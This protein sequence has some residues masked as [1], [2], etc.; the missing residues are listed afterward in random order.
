[1][2]GSCS[3]TSARR[4]WTGCAP[5][6]ARSSCRPR[7]SSACAVR[8]ATRSRVGR[9][10]RGCSPRSSARTCSSC[11]WTGGGSGIAITACSAS[12]LRRRLSSTSRGARP[13]LHARA[14]AWHLE[15][16][17]VREAVH[18]ALAA[19][20]QTAAR[21]LVATHW[22]R[23]FNRGRL[24]TVRF[25]LDAL[26]AEAVRGDP[27]LCAARAWL[28]LDD[29]RIDE[30]EPWILAAERS[31]AE[32]D[33][34]PSS[35]AET[36]VLRAVH[37]F[38]AGD[39]GTAGAAARRAR[40]VAPRRRE[41]LARPSP[42]ASAAPRSTGPAVPRRQ[43]RRSRKH[44]GSPAR[45]PTTWPRPTRPGISLLAAVEGGRLDEADE[46]AAA[47]I[48]LSEEPGSAGHFVLHV[49]HLALAVRCAARGE[50][51]GAVASAQRAVELAERAG[52]VRPRPPTS[53]SH[54]HVSRAVSGPRRVARWCERRGAAGL[55]RRCGR[56]A[57]RAATLDAR[58]SPRAHRPRG[59]ARSSR[60][61]SST[62]CGCSPG[63]VAARDRRRALRL[64]GHGED[65]P[66]RHLPQ[67]AG[68]D[69]LRGG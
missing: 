47:A 69:P 45:T 61:V 56:R 14:L 22:S 57:A 1:M 44:G 40:E 54:G 16:G 37:A 43:P 8:C 21:E 5:R 26:D 33:V 38:K 19:D 30:A 29:G 49:A 46:L 67:V 9:T 60:D 20:D 28:A 13:S 53:S 65:A 41:L 39:V 55:V 27:R 51:D 66:A 11:R 3:T 32:A 68:R 6:C 42:S 23:Y 62:C 50:L 59:R 64:P 25:W 2:T 15:T 52:A 7:S 24:A 12:L 35:R 18:H 17:T 63:P 58:L 31:M 10:R 48:G 4:C 36:A 34:P